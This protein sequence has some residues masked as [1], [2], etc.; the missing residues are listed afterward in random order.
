MQ[1]IPAFDGHNDVLLRLYHSRSPTPEIDFLNGTTEGHLDLPRARKG[2][3]AGGLFA[4]YSPSSSKL[5]FENMKG[6]YDIPLPLA[7]G[8]DEARRSIVAMTSI[9]LRIAELSGGDVEICSTAG[10]IAAAMERNA[11]AV[12]LHLEGAEC[13]DAELRFLDVLYA[14]GL[15][16]LG[17]LWSRPNIFGHGAPMRFP[18][19][20]DSGH[21]LTEIGQA[22][23][24]KCNELRI[25]VDVSHLTEAGFWDVAKCSHAPLVATHSNVH[26][27]CPVPRNLTDRQLDAIKDTGGLVGLNFAT[28][29]LRRDGQMLADTPVELMVEHLDAMIERV[30]EDHVALGSDFDGAIIPRAIGSVVDLQVLFVALRKRGYSDNLLHKIGSKNWLR[31]LASTIG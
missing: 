9:V 15:R 12:V 16:S 24:R 31:I 14:C 27:I 8:M 22:L 29:F 10:S 21:G 3:L 11:L 28:C 30:G 4:L 6:N 25:M 13:V 2:G 7:L 17:P 20:P 19:S 1:L 5:G 18:G 26:A 23:V